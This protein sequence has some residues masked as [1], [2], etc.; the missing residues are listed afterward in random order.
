MSVWDSVEALHAFT[1][2]SAHGQVFAARRQWFDDW[3]SRVASL[4]ELG[5]GAPFLALWWIRAGEIPTA[6]E[7]IRRLRLLGEHGPHA[8]AF[9]FK[10]MFTP[11]GEPV[12]RQ[13]AASR[14]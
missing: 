3:K 9:T 5:A 6:A 10:R 2:R 1:Y 13:V 11:Q 8:Q 4:P 12:E 7:G 14:N